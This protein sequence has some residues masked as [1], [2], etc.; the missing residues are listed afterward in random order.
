MIGLV[1]V[2]RRR[3]WRRCA[4]H[5]RSEGSCATI[6][7]PPI[8]SVPSDAE[9]VGD[10]VCSQCGVVAEGYGFEVSWDGLLSRPAAVVAW[11]MSRTTG[12]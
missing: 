1:G 4:G 5:P 11:L 6:V 2:V 9:A 3:V 12:R 8:E 10:R 7:A